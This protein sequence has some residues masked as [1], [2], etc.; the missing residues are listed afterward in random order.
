[1]VEPSSDDL[2]ISVQCGL[3][4]ISRSGWYYDP[5]IFPLKTMKSPHLKASLH[6]YSRDSFFLN[7]KCGINQETIH[8]LIVYNKCIMLT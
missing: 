3:L 5:L 6:Y 2:S 4:S 8:A 1:M 7:G